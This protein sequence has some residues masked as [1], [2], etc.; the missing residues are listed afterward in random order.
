MKAKITFTL[1]CA[2]FIMQNLA[3]QNINKAKLDSLFDA[4]N[5]HQ[6]SM[7]SVAISKN[8][9]IIYENAIGYQ[10]I[11]GTEKTLATVNT[12][13]RIG[14]ISKMFTGT[15]I[16]QLIE[17]GKL[18]LNTKLADYFPQIPNAAQITIGE[19]LSHRSG[20]YNFTNDSTYVSYYQKPHTEAE[21]LTLIKNYKPA[22]EPNTKE[23]YSNTNFVLLGYMLEKIYKKSYPQI[24][25]EKIL[26][27]AELKNTY[28]GS[29]TNPQKNEA[30]SYTFNHEKWNQEPETDMSIPGGAGAIV[31]TPADLDQFID[32]L[33][34][35]KLISDSSLKQMQTIK[36][37]YG[38]AMIMIPFYDKKAFGHTGGIDG[39]RSVLSYFP[40]DQLA[41]AACANGVNYELNSILIGVLSIYFDKP[42]QIPDFKT[43][44]INEA[45]F[46]NYTGVYSSKQIPLKIT[47]AKKGDQLSAQANGQSAFDLE[48]TA[49]N[50]FKF[51]PAHIE[52]DF[53]PENHQFTLKQGNSYLFTKEN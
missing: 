50:V 16:F 48:Q 45:D 3:A 2:V 15:M 49:K 52:I 12:R 29:K 21:M 17:A 7:L 34:N 37:G 36:D 33:F 31:S 27:P 9:K 8:G 5:T 22:F 38:M 35:G 10:S 4:L 11:N 23:E 51:E 42:Y 53:D 24:L 26:V 18:S 14:S 46:S 43:L 44:S 13:Y 20:I 30:Y 47:I 6:K 28:Y 25:K 19:M 32:A 1:L 39:F 41:V 40:E